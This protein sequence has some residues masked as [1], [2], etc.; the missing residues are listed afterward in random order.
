MRVRLIGLLLIG[1]MS[2]S[3][4]NVLELQTAINK[5]L[6]NNFD[7]AL[8][9]L[10]LEAAQNSA[11]AGNAG[12]LPSV[13]FNGGGNYSSN[14][15]ELRFA[16][17]IPPSE[18]AAQNTNYNASVG[19]NYALFKGFANLRTFDKLKENENLTSVQLE[20]TIE[21]AV[22]TVIGLYYDLAKLQE[23]E[24]SLIQTIDISQT[25]LLR[26]TKARELGSANTL[27]VLNAQVDLHNDSVSLL[28]L[29]NQMG[30]VQRQLNFLMGDAIENSFLV[31]T[32]VDA[33]E[34]FTLEEVRS[35]A[36]ANNTALVMA[37][38]REKISE[39]DKDLARANAM[40][41]VTLNS[42][43]GYS[44]SQNGAGIV[45]EQNN[46]GFSTGI[47]VSVP[48][49]NGGKVRTAVQN[50][51]L[52]MQK[53]SIQ[54]T[55]NEVSVDKEVLDHWNNYLY[56]KELLRIEIANLEAAKQSVS[57]SQES[58]KIGQITSMEFRQ[59]QLQLLASK[60]RINAARYNL[61]KS[62]YQLIRLQGKLINQG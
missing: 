59:A 5:V 52:V 48:I 50:A 16:G 17:G 10:D 28:S 35:G 40:P 33:F 19:L 22:T 38:I 60:N 47:S 57:R 36:K 31:N 14:Y 58:Y 4:Q 51:E 2:A 61:K 30:A 39:L 3:A 37:E 45:L 21:N 46:L 9:Q 26:A 12:L 7:V 29:R 41:S 18:G 1:W 13:S 49:F 53:N 11:T 62:E 34:N 43:Y 6:S 15:T 23:D 44:A 20:L 32:E 8:G 42:S 54:R 25:R 56:F 27:E 55:Q 24:V